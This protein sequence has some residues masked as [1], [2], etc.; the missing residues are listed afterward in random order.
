MPLS[1]T[2]W[3]AAAFAPKAFT[4]LDEAHH[5]GRVV[6]FTRRCLAAAWMAQP[7]VKSVRA[8]SLA[9][10][11]FFLAWDC[12][13]CQV[14]NCQL[15]HGKQV[16]FLVLFFIKGGEAETPYAGPRTAP[17][18]T[19][20]AA[21]AGAR[22]EQ[23]D[24]ERT[25]GRMAGCGEGGR[26]GRCPGGPAGHACPS[27][28]LRYCW[29]RIPGP[30]RGQPQNPA[31]K[32]K[33]RAWESHREVRE[34]LPLRLPLPALLPVLGQDAGPRPC[35]CLKG[36]TG[37]LHWRSR[38]TAV[39]TRHRHLASGPELSSSD[40]TRSTSQALWVR[41]RAGP[42]GPSA[43]RS[44]WA[45]ATSRL[46]GVR[47]CGRA[48]VVVG[49]IRGPLASGP[50]AFSSP[51]RDL[52]ASRRRGLE[53]RVLGGDTCHSFCLEQSP[54]PSPP[55]GGV[56]RVTGPAKWGGLQTA[57]VRCRCWTE[58][59]GRTE[60]RAGREAPSTS[61]GGAACRRV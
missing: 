4:C 11:G 57:Q 39:R 26:S 43:L 36:R 13:L 50:R 48:P 59:R 54:G 15:P 32:G 60:D 10:S 31:R 37:V 30:S 45:V 46:H 17:L 25:V 8:A 23:L 38:E 2:A 33:S 56:C 5:P 24:P 53:C 3:E 34:N 42:A 14:P 6:C 7:A 1:R 52:L 20:W 51:C 44:P 47:T 55:R 28:P 49:G 29:A 19:C 12:L 61:E 41:P 18:R 16:V 40:T 35:L 27:F 21:G 9:P 58:Y 22:R